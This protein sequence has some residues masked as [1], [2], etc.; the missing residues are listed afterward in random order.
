MVLGASGFLGAQVVRQADGFARGASR[1]PGPIEPT[2][3]VAWEAGRTQELLEEE[4][5]AAV[6]VCAA[7]SR[8]GDCEAR[9]EEAWALNVELP[10]EV[11]RW[12]AREHA[13]CVHVSTDLV[14]GL[15]APPEGGFR[16]DHEPAPVGV[17]A[18]TKLEGERA[19]LA[20]E[21]RAVVARLPLLFGDS[22]GRG[23]GASDGLLADLAAGRDVGLFVDEYRTPLDVV[24]AA[25]ALLE[26]ARGQLFGRLH[27]AGP[28]RLSRHELG[29]LVLDA[30][31]EG[32]PSGEVRAARSAEHR[33][34]PPRPRDVSLDAREAS[35]VL[36]CE[37]SRPARALE[38]RPPRLDGAQGGL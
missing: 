11:A 31:P 14:F 16:E 9:A 21:P 28:E 7:L 5:P 36:A 1:A 15:Q 4:R 10:R 18:T 29:R 2:S 22:L 24:E 19:V 32:A 8:V 17:Y 23:L 37:L 25:R 27:L 34:D 20:E 26:L 30:A 6:I 12:C 35:E 38:L 3:W 33:A 13:R